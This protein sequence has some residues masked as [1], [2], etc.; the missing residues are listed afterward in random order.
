MNDTRIAKASID[1]QAPASRVWDALTRP[2]L[3]RQYLFGTEVVTDWQVG[4]PI[5]YKGVWEGKLYEDKGKILHVEPGKQIVSTYWSPLSGL[6][7]RLEYYKTVQ[8]LLESEGGTTHLTITQDNNAS[9]EEAQHS[10]QNWQMV[11]EGIKKLVET[12]SNS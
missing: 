3:V 9:E 8:Y 6:P 4:S 10:A 1:I 7:D 12:G 2:E 5:I 11:L